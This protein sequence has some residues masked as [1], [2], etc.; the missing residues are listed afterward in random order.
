MTAK[1]RM[2]YFKTNCYGNKKS[3]DKMT[4]WVYLGKYK[5]S[6]ASMGCQDYLIFEVFETFFLEAKALV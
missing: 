4:E 2:C 1:M 3:K 5:A 6:E